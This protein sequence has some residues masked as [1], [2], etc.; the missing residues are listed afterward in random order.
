[1][2]PSGSCCICERA[3]QLR[4][5]QE[6]DRWTVSCAHCGSFQIADALTRAFDTARSAGWRDRQAFL[7]DLSQLT[8]V[9]TEP[10]YLTKESWL[11]LVLEGRARHKI[12][13]SSLNESEGKVSKR[14]RWL[15]APSIPPD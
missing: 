7:A 12:A 11:A 1:M 14:C 8:R 2:T 13:R 5:D 4:Y 9:A 6:R 10:L 15:G 3:A